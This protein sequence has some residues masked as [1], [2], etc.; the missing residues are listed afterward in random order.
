MAQSCKQQQERVEE[1]VLQPSDQWVTQL[2]QQCQDQPCNWW[3]LCLNKLLC[4]VIVALVKVSVWVVTIVVRWLYPMVCT[5]VMLVVGLLALLTGN[6]TILAQALSDIWELIK[7]GTY[8]MIGLVIFV[9][10]RIVDLVQSA[11]G[12]QPRKRH[13]TE[14]ERSILAPIFRDSLNYDAIELVV[15]SAGILTIFGTAFTMGFTIYLPMYNERTLVHECVHTWQFEFRGFQY[16][17]NSTLTH[18]DSMAFNKGYSPYDWKTHIDAGDSWYTLKSVE[19]QAQFIEDVYDS[20]D[21]SGVGQHWGRFVFES[22]GV[23]DDTTPGAFFKEDAKLGHNVF[24]VGVST[25]T[26]QANAAWHIIRTA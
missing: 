3:T 7:D 23:P 17:G 8:A 13:L 2:Q 24:A 6:S 12:I 14:R 20:V 22:P 21:D 19:A 10:L 11:L 16:I 4:W 18:L 5:I 1:T 26:E 25:Y 9:A 15:G